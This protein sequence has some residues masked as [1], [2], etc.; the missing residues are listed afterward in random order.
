MIKWIHVVTASKVP[1]VRGGQASPY[2][3]YEDGF[4]PN[5]DTPFGPDKE[6]MFLP[7]IS[8]AA[9]VVND[10]IEQVVQVKTTGDGGQQYHG[11]YIDPEWVQSWIVIPQELEMSREL[12]KLMLDVARDAFVATGYTVGPFSF[13]LTEHFFRLLADRLK[14][15]EE[16]VSALEVPSNTKLTFSD[17]ADKE[18]SVGLDSLRTHFIAFGKEYLGMYET[19]VDAMDSIE[20]ASDVGMVNNVTWDFQGAA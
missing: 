16:A 20:S 7:V 1:T 11:E 4:D 18:V 6:T 9:P 5:V 14:W 3:L 17:L 2:E 8:P 15:L 19:M 10:V 13:P 12:K